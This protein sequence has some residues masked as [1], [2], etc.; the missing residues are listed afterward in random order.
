MMSGEIVL[1]AGIGLAIVIGLGLLAL[2]D[3]S[4]S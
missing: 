2:L 1:I 4:H 3:R